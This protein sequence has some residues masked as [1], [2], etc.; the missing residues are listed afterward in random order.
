MIAAMLIAKS[1]QMYGF[2]NISYYEPLN[3][4]H[5][6]IPGGTRFDDLA[7]AIG[8][9]TEHLKELNP[10]IFLGYIPPDVD[11]HLIR[12][13]KGSYKLVSKFVRGTLLS[14]R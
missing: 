5:F 7:E 14:E 12:I 10:E 8:V 13:P 2:H 11:G 3:F 4:E 6:R 1:P 9:T